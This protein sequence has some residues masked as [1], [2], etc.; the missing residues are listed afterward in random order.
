MRGF[1]IWSARLTWQ[2]R[3]YLQGNG[4]SDGVQR[5]REEERTGVSIKGMAASSAAY[6]WEL[7]F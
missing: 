1:Q 2:G 4:W 3:S 7:G 5:R 6:N